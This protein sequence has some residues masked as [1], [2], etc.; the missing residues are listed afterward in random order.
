MAARDVFSSGYTDM[1]MEG[2][3]GLTCYVFNV[4]DAAR[5]HVTQDSPMRPN[6]LMATLSCL[7]WVT[8]FEP[9]EPCMK[10]QQ[11]HIGSNCQKAKYITVTLL[12]QN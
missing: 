12:P 10:P 5:C 1:R 11:T 8:C 4:R 2:L 6:P 3:G 7:A 9:L